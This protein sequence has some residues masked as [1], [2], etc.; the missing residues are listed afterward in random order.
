MIRRRTVIVYLF[1]LIVLQLPLTIQAQAAREIVVLDASGPLTP[2]MAEYLERGIASAESRMAEALILRLDTPGGSIDLMNRMVR[3]IRASKVPVIVYI[4]PRGAIAGSAGTILTLAGHVAVMAP[5]T[6]IGAASPVGMQGEELGQTI[7]TKAKEILKATARSLA[8]WRG[9]DAVA[10]AEAT[11]D[12][13]K[14]ASAAEALSV[15]LIDVIANDLDDLLVKLDG[16]S[17]LMVS[18]ST[19]LD[20]ENILIVEMKQ[21]FIEELLQTLTNPNIVFL[22]L[23]IGVQALLIELSSPGGWI[24]G[25]IGVV[26]LSLG[27]YGLGI[28]PVNWFGIIFLITAF[29]LFFL[30][31]KAPTHGAMAAAGLIVFIVGSMILFNSPATPAFQRVSISLIISMGLFTAVFFFV[32]VSFALRAQRR[33][34][35]VGSEV[36]IGRIGAARTDLNPVGMVQVGGELWTAELVEIGNEV[37]AGEQVEVVSV[38]G[39][40]VRVIPKRHA[41]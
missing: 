37:S 38:D 28:L 34:V 14:A 9:E 24:A 26:C 17:V 13:A 29:V 23:T 12:E 7:E 36:L 18:G 10:L 30:E 22:L 3:A 25:F 15:G 39:L 20:F 35:A 11:I 21:S 32:I 8:A 16:R 31:V 5:E 33:P 6:A 19:D 2:V 41:D 4:A 1:L 40:R 27:V